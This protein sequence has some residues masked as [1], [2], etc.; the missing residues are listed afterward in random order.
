MATIESLN[1]TSITDMPRSEALSLILEIR[2][3]RR[4]PVAGTKPKQSTRTKRK[5]VATKSLSSL[6]PEQAAKLLELL[7]E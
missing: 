7:G 6:T 2:L 4:T 3:L 1:Y 5:E